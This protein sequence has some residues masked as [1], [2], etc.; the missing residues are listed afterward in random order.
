MTMAAKTRMIP[1]KIDKNSNKRGY[2]SF[3]TYMT[4]INNIVVNIDEAL[5]NKTFASMMEDMNNALAKRNTRNVS[6]TNII[7]RIDAGNTVN[8]SRPNCNK[9][10]MFKNATNNEYLCW[11]DAFVCN[12]VQ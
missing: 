4:D 7:Y 6:H 2:F 3:I 1:K 12:K 10:A 9:K 11:Y 8:C 5:Y